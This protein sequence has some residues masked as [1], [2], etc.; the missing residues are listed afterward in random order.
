M[1][2]AT[3]FRLSLLATLPLTLAGVVVEFLTFSHLPPELQPYTT[4]GNTEESFTPLDDVIAIICLLLIPSIIIGYIGLYRWKSWARPLFLTLIA[5]SYAITPF[6]G[7]HVYS[8]LTYA[9]YSL[10]A[11]LC[12]FTLALAYFS[13]VA[14]KFKR[15]SA[16]ANQ[17][18][19]LP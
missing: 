6:M 10:D 17:L 5:I 16:P 14:E 13:P 15:I 9:I 1:N 11:L 3:L 19:P 4:F 8:G 2:P 18:H 12:G 7:N